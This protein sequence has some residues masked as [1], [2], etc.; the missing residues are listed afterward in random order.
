MSIRK[1]H[2]VLAV[3]TGIGLIAIWVTPNRAIVGTWILGLLAL[4]SW[5]FVGLYGIRSNWRATAAGR[6]VMRLV[7]CMGLICTHGV[8]TIVTDYSY[9]GLTIIRPIL[10][11]GILLAV[12]DLL[13]TLVRIQR[14]NSYDEADQ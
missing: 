3:A 1:N 5:I 13:L 11:L 10:L 12:L 8:L 4:V 9:P 6:A 7:A 14:D 2:V